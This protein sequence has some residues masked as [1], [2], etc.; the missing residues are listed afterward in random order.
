MGFKLCQNFIAI[1]RTVLEISVT[2]KS[3]DVSIFWPKIG[4]KWVYGNFFSQN[5]NP[6]PNLV[7]E[8][9]FKNVIEKIQKIV[10]FSF[11]GDP[12]LI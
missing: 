9:I 12:P 2:E 8:P 4:Q 7:F 5:E 10:V 1:R 6:S 11:G 3:A